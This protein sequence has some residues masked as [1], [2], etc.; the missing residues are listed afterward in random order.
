MLIRIVKCC[1]SLLVYFYDQFRSNINRVLGLE[2]P[3]SWVVL[4]YHAVTRKQRRRFANQMENLIKFARPVPAYFKEPIPKG[5]HHVA[6]TF[7]DGFVSVIENAIPELVARQ[8]PCTIFVPTGSLGKHPTWANDQGHPF[9]RENVISANQL[10]S[11]DCELISIGSH[12]VTHL[13][14]LLLVEQEIRKELIESREMLELILRQDIKLLSFPHGAYNQRIL[15][16]A[17]QAGY[18]R[19]FTISPDIC[20]SSSEKY[21]IGRVN[22]DPD[23]WYMEFRLKSLGSYRWLPVAY[24]LKRKI[25]ELSFN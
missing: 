5:I 19:V 20:F 12:C 4:Y 21:V 18:L 1:V 24:R 2:N 8:I 15:D 11:L 25:L 22:V 7:D 13:N 23:D 14:L 16:L 6:V 9:Y 10:K 3:G 17:R